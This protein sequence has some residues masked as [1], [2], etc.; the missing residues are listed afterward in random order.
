MVFAPRPALFFQN[1]KKVIEMAKC[2]LCNGKI[3]PWFDLCVGC[4]MIKSGNTVTIA[5]LMA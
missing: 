1:K 5:S 4:N 3:K 2:E